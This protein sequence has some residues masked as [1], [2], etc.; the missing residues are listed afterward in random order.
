MLKRF[1][2][3]LFIAITF[4]ACNGQPP[5]VSAQEERYIMQEERF[6]I[7][8]ESPRPGDP[9]TIAANTNEKEALLIVN[10]RQVGKAQ[11]FDVPAVG[12]NPGFRAAV[13][14]LPAS[15]AVQ[16]A[17]I[18]MVN[19]SGSIIE[20]PFTITPREFRSETLTF[21]AA[22]SN[23][24]NEPNPERVRE[25]ERLWAIWNTTG[26]Q[27]YHSGNFM[28]PVTSTRRTSPFGFRRTNIYTDGKRTSSVHM[29]IDFGIPTGTEVF[30]CAR[31]RVVLS[32]SRILTGFTVVLE[33]APG[34]YTMYYHLDSVTAEEGSIVET[35]E[36]IGLSGATGMV[37]GP[38]LHWELR[39][40]GEFADP[41]VFVERP[42]IDKAL[43]I[44]RLGSIRP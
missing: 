6:T 20:I 43:I 27:I 12:R 2:I 41:D 22:V 16:N 18:K 39:I 25:A 15:T 14:T 34:I 9:I 35:G 11:F 32:R 38:H 13:I 1:L 10:D 29:G 44:S 42:L 19:H 33:H 3:F 5:A 36:V 4:T 40:N 7:I 28:L 37:T 23:L 8:P 17:V 26:D 21:S 30:A 24:V 31:G